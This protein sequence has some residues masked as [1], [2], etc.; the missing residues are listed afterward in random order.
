MSVDAW[1]MRLKE[2]MLLISPMEYLSAEYWYNFELS[3]NCPA[4]GSYIQIYLRDAPSACDA[5]RIIP[6]ILPLDELILFCG[7]TLV[8]GVKEKSVSWALELTR[9]SYATDVRERCCRMSV[10]IY[11]IVFDR[12]SLS[13]MMKMVVFQELFLRNESLV[14]VY[15][16]SYNVYP[17][18]NASFDFF[19]KGAAESQK[20]I[21]Y[22]MLNAPS[23]CSSPG[24]NFGFIMTHQQ[25]HFDTYVSPFLLAPILSFGEL[26]TIKNGSSSSWW[27]A[28]NRYRC[29]YWY[30]TYDAINWTQAEA[31]CMA[32]GGHLFSL[33]T[34]N[35][36]E[37]LR[38][39]AGTGISRNFYRY[40]P[41]H[42]Y[43]RAEIFRKRLIFL[44]LQMDQKVGYDRHELEN[45]MQPFCF[46]R[47]TYSGSLPDCRKVI[48]GSFRAIAIFFSKSN[49]FLY[50]YSFHSYD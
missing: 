31:T 34:D 40:N 35:E 45:K 17:H 8:T 4:M 21:I 6:A 11:P 9:S 44:G 24:S 39:W 27:H 20:I 38:D 30:D 29:Y 13:D 42:I 7:I 23:S 48:L 43:Y 15:Y 49:I 26:C 22:P 37:S 19:I 12:C 33:N 18:K 10:N 5:K 28:C 46:Q 47:G 41:Q 25:F 3:S 32:K 50:Y 36:L 1:K 2:N 14:D 16:I